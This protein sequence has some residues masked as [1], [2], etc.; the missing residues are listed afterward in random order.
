[1]LWCMIVAHAQWEQGMFFFFLD[2][3]EIARLQ[4][5][6]FPHLNRAQRFVDAIGEIDATISVGAASAFL[7]VAKHMPELARGDM[8]LRDVAIEM[9]VKPTT[10]ARHVDR[11]AEGTEGT[12]R[13]LNLLEKGVHPGNRR[14]RHVRL[15][16]EGTRLLSK[17]SD[18][19]G[20]DERTG[21]D[22]A[23]TWEEYPGT[24][25]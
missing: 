18:I 3:D 7:H 22:A 15:T 11:L 6:Q 12:V 5:A 23:R 19:I 4:V 21:E 14:Q 20:A 24:E 9:G 16:E 25:S 13:G 10:L 2:P 1:M 8:A 17:L